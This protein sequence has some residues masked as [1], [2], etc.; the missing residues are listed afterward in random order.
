MRCRFVPEFDGVLVA[1]N[2]ILLLED[3]AP[4]QS[5][6]DGS[7]WVKFRVRLCVWSPEP[8]QLI[9]GKI[10]QKGHDYVALLIQDTW[11]ASIP[12][13]E[14]PVGFDINADILADTAIVQFAVKQ[15]VS[16]LFVVFF[17]CIS[18][19]VPPRTS[20]SAVGT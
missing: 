19:F 1:F 9:R 18:P 14:F 6:T 16:F 20:H 2:D 12:F 8:G 4:L 10:I 17:S 7:I 11:N 3:S 5:E 13:S 15:F